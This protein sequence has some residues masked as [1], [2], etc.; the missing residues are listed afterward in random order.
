MDWNRRFHEQPAPE[1]IEEYRRISLDLDELFTGYGR[2]DLN[3]KN[4]SVGLQYDQTF[5]LGSGEVVMDP[6]EFICPIALK[7]WIK[8]ALN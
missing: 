1:M 3:Q 8:H 2:P 4:L 7:F 6:E 5:F